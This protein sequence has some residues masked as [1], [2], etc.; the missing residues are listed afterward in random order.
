MMGS[1]HLEIARQ[2][3]GDDGVVGGTLDVGVAAQGVDAAA[4]AA[5][6]AEQ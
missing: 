4:R 3:A 6:V 2:D 1:R 5:D